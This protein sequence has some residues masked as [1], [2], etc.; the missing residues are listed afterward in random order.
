LFGG[1]APADAP[2]APHHPPIWTAPPPTAPIQYGELALKGISVGPSG[3][4]AMINNETLGV[5]ESAS[6]KVKDGHVDVVCKEIHDD[7]V[8]VTV[9]GKLLELKMGGH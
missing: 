6:V 1:S 7:S 3:R 5:G 8:V 9:N 2:E 4:L